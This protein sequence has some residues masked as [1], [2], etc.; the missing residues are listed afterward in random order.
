MM[1][2]LNASTNNQSHSI[3][4]ITG[5]PHLQPHHPLV[6]FGT[7]VSGTYSPTTTT[8][9][10]GLVGG[11]SAE[12]RNTST[13]SG[14]VSLRVLSFNIWG[15]FNSKYRKQRL[16]HF[17]TKIQ[18]YDVICLQEQFG[19]ED[20]RMLM[21]HVPAAV[22]HQLHFK[23]F[24]SSFIGSGLVIISKFEIRHSQYYTYPTQSH[25]EKVYHGDCYARK[26]VA[27][28]RLAIPLAAP[29]QT[30]GGSA[31]DLRGSMSGG[32]GCS[33]SQVGGA[34]EVTVYTTHL[35]A[36]YEKVSRLGSFER[37]TYAAFR[38]SQAM[39]LASFICSTSRPWDNVILTGDFNASP[40]SPEMKL[41]LA[42]CHCRGGIEFV[43]TL[44]DDD[45][46]NF[47]YSF[48]NEFNTDSTS[49]LK[50]MDMQEDIP[51]QLDHI[52]FS[53]PQLT[54][55]PAEVPNASDVS[56]VFQSI[57]TEVPTG[58]VVFTNNKEVQTNN[59]S[60]PACPIS[61]H[62]GVCARFQMSGGCS[63]A[64]VTSV[65]LSARVMVSA[66]F[67]STRPATLLIDPTSH[68]KSLEFSASF[69]GRSAHQLQLQS[70]KF[71]RSALVLVLFPLVLY[72]MDALIAPQKQADKTSSSSSVAG[73]FEPTLALVVELLCLPPIM[74]VLG[75]ACT[76]LVLI[77]KLQRGDDAIIMGSQAEE[78]RSLIEQFD[79]S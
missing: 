46:T 63:G 55:V 16:T 62:F 56:T 19:E 8:V 5:T 3:S 59:P 29:L 6:S 47:T 26:G 40:S 33:P 37:E 58:V 27:M 61:D 70:T 73:L 15:I 72:I 48:E 2:S 50:F 11:S 54:L 10:G 35:V 67:T 64:P 51:V 74:F 24:P 13:N 17:A 38:V 57:N 79:W 31:V 66:S 78:L 76:A 4:I 22:K 14:S 45:V 42:M 30:L 34:T 69:L 25:P 41:L 23:R 77:A 21:D 39:A 75:V 1:S 44:V 65:P 53:G 18:D 32:A 52:L 60:C 68:R 49:Y 7:N 9:V 43:R 12:G 36:Q 71:L 28:V 20:F